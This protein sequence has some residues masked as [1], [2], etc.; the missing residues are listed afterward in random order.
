[1]VGSLTRTLERFGTVRTRA[2]GDV[3]SV[4]LAQAGKT[5]FSFQIARRS[6]SID[7]PVEG[8]WPGGIAL[9]TL[10]ELIAAKMVALVERGAPR[11]LRDIHS[12]CEAGLCSRQKCWQLWETRQRQGHG[13]AGR[14]RARTAIATHL[15]RLAVS[16]PLDT[17]S[18]PAQRERAAAL[19]L[20][21]EKEFLA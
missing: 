17:I 9:D 6:A 4:E 11:D 21:F 5:T 16:R 20:W 14:A 15:A 7:A 3:V 1:M 10:E 19:R 2:W 12:L 8:L 18:D 13:D